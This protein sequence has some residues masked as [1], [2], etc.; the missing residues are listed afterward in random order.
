MQ[1]FVITGKGGT[2]QCAD[3]AGTWD[4]SETVTTTCTAA[5]HTETTTRSGEDTIDIEQDGCQ[6]RWEVPDVD[7]PR[8]GVVTGNSLHATG[9]FLLADALTGDATFTKNQADIQGTIEGNT[10]HLSGTGIAT[11]T[12]CSDG[13]CSEFSCTG[14]STGEFTR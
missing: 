11:G 10:I 3:I 6:I 5:G 13:H 7:A 4:A 1:N 8:T 2:P 9:D 14:T 12:L